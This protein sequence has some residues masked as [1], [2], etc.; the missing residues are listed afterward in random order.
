[1]KCNLKIDNPCVGVCSTTT[2]GSI[3]C[4]GCGRHYKDVIGWN[5]FDTDQK[6]LA[7]H[8]AVLH[9]ARKERGETDDHTDYLGRA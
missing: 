4:V 7:M 1:M 3:W 8:R 9:K 6:I 2:V 5:G